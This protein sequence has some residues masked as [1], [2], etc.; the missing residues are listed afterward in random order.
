MVVGPFDEEK[1]YEPNKVSKEEL[2]GREIAYSPGARVSL[3][4]VET[5]RKQP[6]D[7]ILKSPKGILRTIPLGHILNLNGMTL[8]KN[9]ENGGEIL[10]ARSEGEI[11]FIYGPLEENEY[12]I[13]GE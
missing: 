3:E 10:V 5:V 6:Y 9:L 7:L 2:G 11:D 12:W 13:P 1:L 4:T 8:V